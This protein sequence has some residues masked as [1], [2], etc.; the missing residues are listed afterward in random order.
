MILKPWSSRSL[1]TLIFER[2]L[3]TAE[4]KKLIL[5]ELSWMGSENCVQ[6]IKDLAAVEELKDEVEYALERLGQ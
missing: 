1:V 3:V 6:A 2:F 4:S 5:R